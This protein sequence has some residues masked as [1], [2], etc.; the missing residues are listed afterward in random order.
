MPTT[1][2]TGL[3]CITCGKVT[4][5]DPSA[6][7]C[8]ACGEEGAGGDP[9]ILD[10]EYDY[11]LARRR[12]GRRSDRPDGIFRFLPLLPLV[13]VA[14]VLT[15]GATALV[16][17]PRLARRLGL[18]AL[19]LKDETRNPTRCLK[20]RSTAVGVSLALE[21]GAESV[22]CASAGNAAISL[23]GYAAH[24]GLH[25]HVFVPGR[26][27]D[28]RLEW[29]RR[30]GAQVHVSEGNYDQAFAESELAGRARGWY[31]RNCAYNPFLVEGKKT[32]ALEIGEQLGFDAPDVVIAP[33]GDGCTLAAIGKGF[34]ELR[35]IG[36]TARVPA[37]IGVQAEGV[38][39]LVRRFRSEPLDAG[40]ET[41]AASISV[42]RPRNA[43]RLLRELERAGGELLAVPDDATAVAQRTLAEEAGIVAEFTSA[44]TLA[45][46]EQRAAELRGQRVVLV[47]TGGRTDA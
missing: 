12:L 46:L 6:Y 42:R 37:L 43:R 34:R 30:F 31:S 45:A 47:I 40:G 38:Q 13:S 19:H 11:D 14:P 25:C 33:V 4:A 27:S 3:R 44:T 24:A 2:V 35:E 16:S 29:L 5:F 7:L 39:P 23:A 15:A 10:V 18:S 8:P 20:D 1:A 21:L 17:A 36:R 26:V 32:A 9:G 28:M 41:R 22:Y